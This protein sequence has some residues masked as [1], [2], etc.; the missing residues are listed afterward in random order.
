MFLC[1]AELINDFLTE[2]FEN[3]NL[4]RLIP[5]FLIVRQACLEG[6]HVFIS[7]QQWF[8]VSISTTNATL[9]VP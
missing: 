9:I 6:A 7:Y 8:A 2:A 4:E 5:A 1:F 3:S